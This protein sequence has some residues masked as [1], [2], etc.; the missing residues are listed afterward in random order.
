MRLDKRKVELALA[1][2][3]I[4]TVKLA[5]LSGMSYQTVN[6]LI[7]RDGEARPETAGMIARALDVKTAEIVKEEEY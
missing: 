7:N 3:R 4:N 6:R 2:K 1:D 5:R